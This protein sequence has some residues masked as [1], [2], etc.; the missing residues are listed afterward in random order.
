MLAQMTMMRDYDAHDRSQMH[1]K[2]MMQGQQYACALAEPF[3][4]ATHQMQMKVT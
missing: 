4:L 2:M 3:R 1:N